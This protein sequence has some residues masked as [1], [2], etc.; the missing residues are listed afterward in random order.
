MSEIPSIE[1]LFGEAIELET[2][3][4]RR[5]FI[6]QVC[7]DDHALREQLNQLLAAH[8]QAGVFWLTPTR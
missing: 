7:G 4:Q 8:E 6:D 5:A 3:D 2:F 1:H